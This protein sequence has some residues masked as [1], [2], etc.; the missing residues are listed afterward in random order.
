MNEERGGGQSVPAVVTSDPS[1]A[2]VLGALQAAGALM[3]QE[4]AS[5]V[6]ALGFTVTTNRAYQDQ[7]EGKSREL[8]VWAQEGRGGTPGLEVV[9]ELLIECK[10]NTNALAFVARRQTTADG[11]RD[12]AEY[13]FPRRRYERAIPGGIVEIP[14]FRAFELAPAHYAYARELKAV[15]MSRISRPQRKW[16]AD[17]SSYESIVYPLAKAVRA[18]QAEVKPPQRQFPFIWLFF[19]IVVVRAPMFVVDTTQ[20]QVTPQETDHVTLTRELR[21]KTVSGS[22]AIDFVQQYALGDLISTKIRPFSDRVVTLAASRSAE[23]L[24]GKLSS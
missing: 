24:S 9:V 16:Q 2:D 3:E 20:T 17:G 14:A 6:E 13:L 15:H 8:D 23:L 22:F 5:V 10:N 11:F 7:D 19:P 4:V 1:P 12:P 21:S 18:R